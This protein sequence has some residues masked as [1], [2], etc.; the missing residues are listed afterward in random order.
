VVAAHLGR[1]NELKYMIPNQIKCL[2]PD[3]DFVDWKGIGEVAV[4]PNRLSLREGPGAIDYQWPGNASAALHA[5]SLQSVPSE[6][7]GKPVIYIFPAWPT[8]WDT[9]FKLLARGAFIVSASQKKGEIEFVTVESKAGGECRLKNQWP[10]DL[11]SMEK[12]G[13]EVEK[14]SGDIL[15]FSMTKDET[16]TL[17]K[18]DPALSDPGSL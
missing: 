7:G 8:E 10:A 3:K 9:D 6:P 5:A 1:A 2:T 13:K 17:V 15:T 4:L 14:I 18:S 12:E 16:I 11:L